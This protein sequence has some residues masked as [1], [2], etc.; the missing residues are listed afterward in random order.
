MCM[1]CLF[2]GTFVVGF[3]RRLFRVSVQRIGLLTAW[4]LSTAHTRWLFLARLV[5]CTKQTVKSTYL[6][7]ALAV[8]LRDRF[9]FFLPLSTEGHFLFSR[10]F[11]AVVSMSPL[12]L[13]VWA[14]ILDSSLASLCVIAQL[15]C[16]VRAQL[17]FLVRGLIRKITVETCYKHVSCTALKYVIPL[18]QD[19]SIF[20]TK[21]HIF[22]RR[23]TRQLYFAFFFCYLSARPAVTVHVP[24]FGSSEKWALASVSVSLQLCPTRQMSTFTAFATCYISYIFL[25]SWID[26]RSIRWHIELGDCLLLIPGRWWYISYTW[27]R[28]CLMIVGHALRTSGFDTVVAAVYI[29]CLGA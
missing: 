26:F 12:C 27:Q 5:C 28:S 29:Y 10:V 13:F 7:H 3:S 1:P 14:F 23:G 19:P 21:I 17:L 16:A 8:I 2:V 11:S 22:W 6:T 4:L 18:T 15:L 20:S 9:F 25:T 24:H